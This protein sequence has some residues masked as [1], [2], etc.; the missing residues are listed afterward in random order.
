SARFCRSVSVCSS[1]NWRSKWSSITALLRP[2]TKMKC[3]IPASRAS[4][5]TCWISGRSTTGRI[6][7]G[8]ALVAGRNRVPSQAT[9]KTA[10]RIG[11][12][13]LPEL[14]L[15]TDDGP[16]VSVLPKS[17]RVM[18][19]AWECHSEPEPSEHARNPQPQARDYGFRSRELHP[20]PEMTAE[21][22]ILTVRQSYRPPIAAEATR[23]LD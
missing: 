3:S 12:M 23:S 10:L 22:L 5:T 6:S 16:P 15:K 1:S 19:C 11:F 8:I 18:K 4:S 21:Q 9:G 20:R 14:L 2:V 17:V 7:L 13:L